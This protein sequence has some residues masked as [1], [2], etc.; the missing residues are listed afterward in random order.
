MAFITYF[1]L[2][3]A[4]IIYYSS[5]FVQMINDFKL[6]SIEVKEC[7]TWCYE[8]GFFIKFSEEEKRNC[9]SKCFYTSITTPLFNY[10]C[11]T[12]CNPIDWYYK[13]GICKKSGFCISYRALNSLTV[14]QAVDNKWY[15]IL[16]KIILQNI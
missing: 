14:K 9:A 12:F 1:I 15:N 4:F 8:E 16:P 7:Q 5:H 6:K 13:N 2:L 3:I 11:N 10:M